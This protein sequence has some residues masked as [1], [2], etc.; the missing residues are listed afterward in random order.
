MPIFLSSILLTKSVA[1]SSENDWL[2]LIK[3]CLSTPSDSRSKCLSLK[4]LILAFGLP[5]KVSGVTEKEITR[6][7]RP[8]SLD[9]CTSFFSIS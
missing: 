8:R 4:L 9:F 5:K 7:G 2:N 1:L 6:D 3:R